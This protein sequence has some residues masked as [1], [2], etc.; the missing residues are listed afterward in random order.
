LVRSA[1]LLNWW[2]WAV[3]NS[4][5]PSGKP[6]FFVVPQ[7]LVTPLMYYS[8]ALITITPSL[9]VFASR[10]SRRAIILSLNQEFR[11]TRMLQA[12]TGS[13]SPTRIYLWHTGQWF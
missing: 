6:Q 13:H 10:A 9:F 11:L 4:R 5:L 7:A 8:Y 3:V 2:R 1:R 12:Q